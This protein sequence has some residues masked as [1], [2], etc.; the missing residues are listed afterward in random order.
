MHNIRTKGVIRNG[1]V[2]M[3]EPI[4]LPNGSEVTITGHANGEPPRDADWDRPMTPGNRGDA[5]GH[6]PSGAVR[7]E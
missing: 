6:G 2:E 4:D 7:D 5:C 3:A 1:Q